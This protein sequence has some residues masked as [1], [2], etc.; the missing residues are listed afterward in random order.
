MKNRK[1][2]TPTMPKRKL[3]NLTLIT[4]KNIGKVM[5]QLNH[6]FSKPTLRLSGFCQKVIGVKMI[7]VGDDC[8][9]PQNIYSDEYYPNYLPY[10]AHCHYHYIWEN[11]LKGKEIWF[12]R[13][14]EKIP[15]LAI[16][17]KYTNGCVPISLGDSYKI[18]GNRLV[19]MHKWDEFVNS[20][21]WLRFNE[22]IQI[23]HYDEEQ[24]RKIRVSGCISQVI[25]GLYDLREGYEDKYF[26]YI[27][28]YI[29]K[30]SVEMEIAFKHSYHLEKVEK[31]ITGKYE[32]FKLIIYPLR[33]L[34]PN[35]TN[36]FM[37]IISEGGQKYNSCI[38]YIMDIIDKK[39]K[40]DWEMMQKEKEKENEPLDWDYNFD[41]GYLNEDFN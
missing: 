34:N 9:I 32:D 28:D 6:F 7:E 29:T 30:L 1:P 19:I 40:E 41:Y 36:D 16:S 26:S 17:G 35:D 14:P 20:T 27:E 23:E 38:K 21:P 33:A 10:E 8:K 2:Y 3:E 5:G 11:Y 31:E 18:Y 39:M 25:D 4:E 12:S 13:E 24:L 15:R 22:F 37:E